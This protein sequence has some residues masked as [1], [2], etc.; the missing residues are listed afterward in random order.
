M[1]TNRYLYYRPIL[2]IL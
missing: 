2:S 1:R